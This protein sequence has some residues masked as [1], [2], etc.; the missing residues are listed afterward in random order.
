[1]IGNNTSTHILNFFSLMFTSCHQFVYNNK[2]N[3]GSLM[4]IGAKINKL[5]LE[6]KLS[7]RE[8]GEKIGISHAHISKL[9]S[10][11]NSPSVDL[12]EKLAVFFNIDITYFFSNE[13]DENFLENESEII[14]EHDLSLESLKG[15]YN[16][17]IAGRPATDEEIEEVIKHIKLYRIMKQM[18]NS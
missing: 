1:M 11:I 17:N 4:D 16:L 15:K 5:R 8:L 18:E 6:K 9:E 10:G 2:A 12:L 13:E 14:Y 3:G 7:M